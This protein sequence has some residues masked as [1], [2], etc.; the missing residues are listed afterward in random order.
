M[1][2]T[3]LISINE[4]A[5][6]GQARRIARGLARSVSFTAA[7]AGKIE[8][9]VTEAATNL[10][11]HAGGGKIILR[12]IGEHALEMLAVDKGPG[13]DITKCLQDGYST[14]GSAGTGLGAISRMA[15]V[16]DGYSQEGRGTV[17]LGQFNS[18]PRS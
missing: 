6:V 17:I 10:V 8:L 4:P 5:Q 7:Q 9:A 2:R 15:Q 18:K 14:T 12:I 16:F 1:T 13:M 11:K 3:T